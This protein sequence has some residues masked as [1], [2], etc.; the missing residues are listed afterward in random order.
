MKN[1][2]RFI[3]HLVII[4]FSIIIISMTQLH[5]I[6]IEKAQN[7]ALVGLLLG[8]ISSHKIYKSF[9]K[10]QKRSSSD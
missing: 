10:E 1:E 4:A 2:T 8:T 3:L 7:V 6:P 5:I 9:K